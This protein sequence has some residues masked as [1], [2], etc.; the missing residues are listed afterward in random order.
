MRRRATAFSAAWLIGLAVVGTGGGA[1]GTPPIA[2]SVPSPTSELAPRKR[3]WE[4]SVG[5][6]GLAARADPRAAR[7][8]ADE[9]AVD[10]SSLPARR[11]R[12]PRAPRAR[13]VA[14]PRRAHRPRERPAGRP[15]A[16]RSP[17]PLDLRRAESATTRT[18]PRRPPPRSRSSR[19][20][21]SASSTRDE[22]VAPRRARSSTRS[23]SSRR[24]AGFFFNYYDTTSLERTS[25]FLSFVD[26]AWLTAGLMVVRT[27]FPELRRARTH[28]DRRSATTASSTT[29][30]RGQMSHGYYV[31]PQRAVALPLRRRST[32]RR[33]SGSLIAIGKGD[34]PRDALVPHVRARSRPSAT[35]QTQAPRGAPRQAGARLRAS[36]AAGTS[37]RTSATCRRGAAACSRR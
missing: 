5:G 26:S 13:H 15:R 22:A 7:R 29:P 37:G 23:S 11:P 31:E 34:V 17:S 9:L 32:P 20:A 27:A 25:N 6:R 30:T 3:A 21:S 33:G 10:P 2:A 35:W 24:Y 18:S 8:L 36:P 4:E 16:L 12:V 1:Q 28:A 19:R 14:R